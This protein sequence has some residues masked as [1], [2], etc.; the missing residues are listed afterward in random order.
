[1]FPVRVVRGGPKV[2]LDGHLEGFSTASS[3]DQTR[4]SHYVINFGIGTHTRSIGFI[5]SF[6]TLP[7][8]EQ[9]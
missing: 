7:V 9:G 1:M 8:I 3:D 2:V 6:S 4:S 5:P